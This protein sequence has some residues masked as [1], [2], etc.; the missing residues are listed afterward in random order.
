[1]ATYC[2]AGK[3]KVVVVGS[4][5]IFNDEFLEKEDNFKIISAVLKY[6]SSTEKVFEFEQN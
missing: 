2:V 3:G 6:M 5:D 1:M 4:V